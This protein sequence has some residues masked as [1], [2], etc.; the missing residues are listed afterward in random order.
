MFS[1]TGMLIST[2]DMTHN[3][4]II[5]KTP[6]QIEGIKKSCRLAAQSLLWIEPH[7][8]A[9]V[10]TLELN[11][12]MEKYIRDKGGIPACLGYKGFP[13]AVCTSVNE[14]VCHGIPG[15]YALKQGDIVNIDVTTVLDGYYGDT[16][17]MYYIP[18]FFPN[19]EKLM[20]VTQECLDIGIAQVRP[21]N[22]FGNLGYWIERHAKRNGFS[23]VW[24]FCGHG[25]GLEFHE[26]PQ[27]SH[28]GER[29]TGDIMKA[30]MIFTVEPMIN[31]G[32]AMAVVNEVD[33]WTAITSDGKL[34][35]QYEHT[36]LVT[37]SGYEIL[38]KA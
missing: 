25:V 37:P 23:V 7:V 10:T 15:P 29:Y 9:G 35:A 4:K 18:P 19:A 13:K 31:E 34:S 38:T 6:E 27:V 16:S 32:S 14:V 12:L 1:A 28:C 8:K 21:G 24:N 2:S 22:Y 33:G 26:P 3:S 36:V 11:D 20:K 5:I 17:R 30:G